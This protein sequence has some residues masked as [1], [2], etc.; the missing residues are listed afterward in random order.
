MCGLKHYSIVNLFSLLFVTPHVGVWIETVYL[1]DEEKKEA[2][3]PH[4]G[5]W[6]ETMPLVRTPKRDLESHLM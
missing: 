1:T 5:V 3:T 4:V 2:V 6:I